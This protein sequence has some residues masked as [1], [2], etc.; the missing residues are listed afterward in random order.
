MT[1]NLSG[2]GDAAQVSVSEDEADCDQKQSE[3]MFKQ[4][5]FP[6][7]ET[8]KFNPQDFPKVAKCIN[9]RATKLNELHLKLTSLESP[10]DAQKSFLG[11]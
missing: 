9:K 10:T 2:D 7:V 5:G 8:N 6:E 1:S 4:I 3:K 11:A